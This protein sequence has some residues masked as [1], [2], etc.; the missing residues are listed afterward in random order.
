[1]SISISSAA[2]V[3]GDSGV[4]VYVGDVCVSGAAGE[5][6]RS[7]VVEVVVREVIQ[8]KVMEAVR[9]T[10]ALRRSKGGET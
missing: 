7:D 1:M 4:P 6:V 3:D 5:G 2:N 9:E 10:Q 8:E